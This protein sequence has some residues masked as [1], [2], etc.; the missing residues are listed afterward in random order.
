MPLLV[1]VELIPHGNYKKKVKI[2]ELYIENDGSGDRIFGNYSFELKGQEFESNLELG[3]QQK[4][5]Y[6]NFE[7]VNGYWGLIKRILN[8]ISV[9]NNC[10]KEN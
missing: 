2:G 6:K 1:T 4:G 8:S 9:D 7:R 3:T 5:Q 10:K